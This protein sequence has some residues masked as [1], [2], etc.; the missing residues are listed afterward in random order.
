MRSSINMILFALI[1]APIIAAITWVGLSGLG[2]LPLD[3]PP[4]EYQQITRFCPPAQ[5]PKN[6]PVSHEP[7]NPQE[8][9]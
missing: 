4:V 7:Q 5:T 1:A 8:Y 2:N 3:R 6:G 9:R